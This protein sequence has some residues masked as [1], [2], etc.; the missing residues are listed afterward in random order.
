MLPIG[1][2]R[3]YINTTITI[4]DIIHGLVFYLKLNSILYACPYLTS[5]KLRLHYESKRMLSID[6]W[7]WYINVTITILDIIHG[8]VF[9]LNLNSTL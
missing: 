4:L 3:W 8:P 1:L 6:L 5:N 9:Y 2:W 7:R